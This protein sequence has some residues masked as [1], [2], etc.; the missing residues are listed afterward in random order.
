M[1]I[2]KI[3]RNIAAEKFLKQA[4]T[5]QHTLADH[6]LFTLARVLIRF[7]IRLLGL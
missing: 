6:P 2:V 3:D 1:S 5:L 4:F 7:Q